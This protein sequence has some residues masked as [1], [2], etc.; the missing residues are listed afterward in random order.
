MN[1]AN[2]TLGITKKASPKETTNS[3]KLTGANPNK[4]DNIG[5]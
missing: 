2:S 1:F 5:I 3:I 4:S